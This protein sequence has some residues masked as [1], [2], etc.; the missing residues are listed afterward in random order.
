MTT[1]KDVGRR[2][3]VSA[4]TVS[5]VLNGRDAGRVQPSI[6][7]RVRL[8]ARELGYA[9]NLV[10]RSLRTNQSHTI[11]LLSDQ[12]AST[13]FAGQMLQ[14][15]QQTAWEAGYLLL[16]IDTAGNADLEKPAIQ[17]LAQRNIDA[18]IYASTYHREVALPEVPSG[19][20]FLLLDGRPAGDAHV[21]WVAPD[22]VAGAAAAVEHFVSRGHRRIGFINSGESIPAARGRLEG[23]FSALRAAG[24]E[25][26]DRLIS[27]LT[28]RSIAATEVSAAALLDL[29]DRPTAI[30]CFNDRVAAGLYREAARRGLSIPRDLSIIGF[31][32]D[33]SVIEH[34]TPSLTTVQLPHRAMGVWAVERLLDGLRTEGDSTPEGFLMP[35]RL[36][37]RDSVAPP[38]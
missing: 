8:A 24:I 9:P 10:A 5:L 17:A 21:D 12:V 11:G 26:D 14:G 27:T 3:G 16:L 36:I 19:T 25:P 38:S 23:Y 4:S 1:L 20:P 22:E 30:F 6:S 15:A 33:Q 34:L 32:D 35:C 7:A 2:A 28:D 37:V 13:P 18:L 29:P 31:D